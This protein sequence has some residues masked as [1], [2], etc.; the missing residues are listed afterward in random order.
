M[1]LSLSLSLSQSLL[2]LLAGRLG[3]QRAEAEGAE[4]LP[5]APENPQCAR[6]R[7]RAGARAAVPAGARGCGRLGAAVQ[8]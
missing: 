1:S 4:K 3:G 7:E 8:A 2:H 6:A 5:K